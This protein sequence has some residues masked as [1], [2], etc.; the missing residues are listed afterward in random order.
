MLPIIPKH[1]IIPGESHLFCTLPEGLGCSLGSQL[2]DTSA[3][4]LGGGGWGVGIISGFVSLPN[5]ASS[6]QS[7][8]WWFPVGRWLYCGRGPVLTWRGSDN[9]DPWIQASPT[10]SA[11]ACYVLFLSISAC[12]TLVTDTETHTYF[13]VILALMPASLPL[14]KHIHTSCP[15][16][17]T[18]PISKFSPSDTLLSNVAWWCHKQDQ[19]ALCSICRRGR[20]FILYYVAVMG[21]DRGPPN[22]WVRGTKGPRQGGGQEGICGVHW[23]FRTGIATSQRSLSWSYLW[24]NII[25]SMRKPIK[26]SEIERNK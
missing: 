21:P 6:F 24:F 20:P 3:C 14:Y 11:S 1:P 9:D 2:L 19:D 16:R 4:G 18:L 26:V 17:F 12:F 25:L 10:H 23:S 5:G 15:L 7:C 8:F 13:P 22:C